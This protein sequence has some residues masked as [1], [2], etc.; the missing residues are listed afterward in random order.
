[1]A[2]DPGLKSLQHLELLIVVA[3]I[4]LLFGASGRVDGFPVIGRVVVDRHSVDV[5]DGAEKVVHARL[6]GEIGDVGPVGRAQPLTLETDED[7]D[8]RGI[9]SLQASSFLEVGLMSR[10]KF[11]QRLLRV[12][13]LQY[14]QSAVD[15]KRQG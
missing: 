12:V 7:M 10:G 14:Y 13:Q 1:M 15:A 3:L 6:G 2:H 9:S 4:E 5:V 8:L 11:R